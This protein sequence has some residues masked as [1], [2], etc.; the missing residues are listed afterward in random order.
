M[1]S[2]DLHFQKSEEW[3]E[4]G[5][6]TDAWAATRDAI[7]EVD[8]ANSGYPQYVDRA[9]G[10]YLWDVDGNRYIDFIMGYGPVVLGH[11]HPEVTEAV[12]GQ[13]ALGT[14]TSPLWNPRQVELTELLTEVIPGAEQAYLLRTGSDATTAAVRLARIHTVRDKVVRWGYNGWHDWAAPRPDGI[15]TSTIADTLRFE[16]N[17]LAS[18]EAVFAKHPDEIACVIMMSYEY[19]APAA[20]F[21]EQVKNLAHRF[22][23]LFVL[24]EMRSGFRISLGGAQEY[25]GVRPD[26]STFS[27]AM[28]NGYPISAVVGRRDVLAGLGRTHMS[29]TFYGNPAEMAAAIIT[30]DILRNTDALARIRRLGEKFRDAL[31][32]L[33]TASGLPAQ[34][35]G[36]PVSPFLR[37]RDPT[38]DPHA[39]RLKTTFFRE[40]LRRGVMFHPN[41]QWFVSA[42][43]TDEDVDATIAACREAL[44][45]TM[46]GVKP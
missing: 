27:K 16:F 23:A 21:L 20:G 36:L 17:D 19:E 30:I 41:H 39:G 8:A 31:D 18:L 34:V 29:S 12:V 4:R 15:P 11:A 22:G 43:H 25:F 3:A 10:A 46:N 13:L 28:S 44:E 24:D 9:Q 2:D 14:C 35:V 33:V 42:A 6:R 32:K 5:R 1:T 37:F 45:V 26:L 38:E 40:T 7:L